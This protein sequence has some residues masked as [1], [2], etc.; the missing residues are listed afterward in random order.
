MGTELLVGAALAAAGAG[1]NAYNQ[2]QTVKHQDEETARG[3][4]LQGQHQQDAN[5]RVN[6]E[7]DAMK[8]SSPEASRASAANDFL[9]Q[10]RRTRAQAVSGPGAVKGS[11][12]AADTADAQSSVSDLGTRTAGLLSRINAPAF[13]RQNEQQGFAQLS[14][15]L[16]TIGRDSA[17]DQFLTQLRLRQARPNAGVGLLGDALSGAGSAVAGGGYG[18]SGPTHVK[19]LYGVKKSPIVDSFTSSTAGLA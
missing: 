17:A 12:Y 7:V 4:A 5:V 16:G 19:S 6:Q 15:D 11:R 13:Q 2:N 1:V 10:L 9:E 14:S 8:N 3:I 18:S